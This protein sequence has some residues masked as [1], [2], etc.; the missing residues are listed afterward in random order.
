MVKKLFSSYFYDKKLASKIRQKKFAWKMVWIIASNEPLSV[1]R[2]NGMSKEY[3]SVRAYFCNIYCEWANIFRTTW[4]IAKKQ[5]ILRGW[6]P[7]N[8][9]HDKSDKMLHPLLQWSIKD[10]VENACFIRY[11]Q[12]PGKMEILKTWMILCENPDNIF[13]HFWLTRRRT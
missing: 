3:M 12:S 1:S 11:E 9:F 8:V 6:Y 5:I 4:K 7:R 13:R 2:D 10:I